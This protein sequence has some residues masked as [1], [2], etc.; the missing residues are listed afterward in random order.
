MSKLNAYHAMSF[1]QPQIELA[2][3]LWRVG[4]DTAYISRLLDIP[5]SIIYN[6]LPKWRKEI[7][8]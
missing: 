3:K 1:S 7:T 4:L 6:N 8:A 5:E 2:L